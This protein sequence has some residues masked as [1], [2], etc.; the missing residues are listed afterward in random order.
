MSP[1]TGSRAKKRL[2]GGALEELAPPPVVVD[3]SESEPRAMSSRKLRR[4]NTSGTS[5]AASVQVEFIDLDA[6][7][8]KQV[9]SQNGR[10][11]KRLSGE[12][13]EMVEVAAIEFRKP[14]I[15][16]EEYNGKHRIGES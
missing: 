8:E 13:S 14:I 16:G 6:C 4:L 5:A 10:K 15:A 2:H 11:S 1:H 7:G 12:S 9:N 3:L